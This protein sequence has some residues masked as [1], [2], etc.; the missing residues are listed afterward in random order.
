MDL[1]SHMAGKLDIYIVTAL[2]NGNK[3]LRKIV[4]K[5]T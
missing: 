4:F 2:G 5:Q 1:L 3:T